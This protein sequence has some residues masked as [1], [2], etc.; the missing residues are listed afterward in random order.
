MKQLETQELQKVL[1][2]VQAELRHRQ[3]T[4]FSPVQEVSSI[5]QTLLKDGALR[6]N[7]PKLSAFSGERVKGEVS[8]E[9]WSYEL[10]S[11]RKTYSDSALREGIQHFLRAAAADTVRNMGP[12][13]RFDTIFKKFTI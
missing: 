9:Q 13:V 5:L 12:D 10:Q 6:T 8:F 1:S 3:D 4:S 7:I 11:L 2:I